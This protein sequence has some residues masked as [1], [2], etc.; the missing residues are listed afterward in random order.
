MVS[1]GHDLDTCEGV[2]DRFAAFDGEAVESGEFALFL[3]GPTDVFGVGFA[4][5]AVE[6]AQS[7]LLGF[8]PGVFVDLEER[9]AEGQFRPIE[10]SELLVDLSYCVFVAAIFGFL[11]APV[12]ACALDGVEFVLEDA[13][14]FEF[15]LELFF[16]EPMVQELV[17]VGNFGVDEGLGW[18]C[19]IFSN[20]RALV[21]LEF[22]LERC[23][24]RSLDGVI[25]LL[26]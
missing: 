18:G 24:S 4:V 6:L 14:A 16:G 22:A 21:A 15:R 3:L 26:L 11:A 9:G 19:E 20:E 23:Q 1:L 5:R 12:E 17:D 13:G 25:D 8:D 7:L 10:G 2:G